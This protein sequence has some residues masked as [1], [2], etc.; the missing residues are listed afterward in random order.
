SS[1]K[2]SKKAGLLGAG[3][4]ACAFT[5]ASPAQATYVL[6]NPAS[7]PLSP[8]NGLDP[9]VGSGA[10]CSPT[11]SG[12]TA[13]GCL[14]ARKAILVDFTGT[15]AEPLTLSGG[16]VVDTSNADGAFQTVTIR[17]DSPFLTIAALA[18]DLRIA[19]SPA[20]FTFSAI[21]GFGKT[22]TF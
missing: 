21:D 16:G 6:T 1:I 4:L 10:P 2:G 7:D 22:V 9:I 20:S 11:L 3:V 14:S 18:V 19:T 5:F 12:I 13:Q 8:S 17:M 15:A